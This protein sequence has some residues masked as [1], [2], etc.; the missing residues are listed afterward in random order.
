MDRPEFFEQGRLSLLADA[1]KFVENALGNLLQPQ[2]RVVGVGEAMRFVAHALQQ[3]QCA[4]IMAQPQRLAFTRPI[5]FLELLRQTNRGKV[6]QPK[7]VQLFARGVELPF[8]A[9][10]ENQV[11]LNRPFAPLAACGLSFHPCVAAANRFRHGSEIVLAN[12]R[13]HFEPPIIRAVGPAT[14]ETDHGRHD[15]RA[16]D[17]RDVEPFDTLRRRGQPKDLAQLRQ[18]VIGGCSHGQ[19]GRNALKLFRFLRR[20]PEVKQHVAQLRRLLEVVRGG[21]LLHLRFQ[22]FLHLP[23]LAVEEIA[24]RQHLHQVLFACHVA[25]A[26]RGADLQMRV[27]TVLVIGFVRCQRTATAQVELV[28]DEV[29]RAPQ[30]AGAGER[31]EVT[32]AIVCLE[33]RERETR[34]RV[35]EVDF[36]QQEPFVVA[37]TDVVT[38]MK[39]LDQLAF[40]QQGLRFTADDVKIEIVDRFD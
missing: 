4:G 35:V 1:G 29:Q 19:P 23:G 31:T 6:A 13:F 28:P 8:T 16:A 37:E 14:F 12:H 38:G 3:L 27:E 33:S 5:D 26:R 32:G 18:V 9:V 40:Q 2:L 10:D 25:D 11:R 30:R 34:D 21:G 24:R 15:E 20:A 22:L 36:Q 17:V 39:F 7:L